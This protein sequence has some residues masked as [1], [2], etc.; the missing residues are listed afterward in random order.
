MKLKVYRIDGTQ[1]EETVELPPA[2]FEI[3]PNQHL[4]HQA[5]KAHLSNRRQGTHKAKERSDVRGG[6]KKPWKQKGRGTARAGT[7]RSPIWIGGGTTH[8]P[9]PRSYRLNMN[10]RAVRLAKKSALSQKA[11]AGEIMVIEDL[12]FEKPVT[13]DFCS[14]LRN[15]KLENKKILVLLAEGNENIYKSGRNIP[16]VR[17]SR[18]NEAATYDLLNNQVLLIQKSALETLCKPLLN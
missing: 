4:M 11:K 17:L 13:K 3:D 18:S 7:N 10:L 1:S 15:L 6:G 5:V 9:R 8:G 12:S 2:I 14:I 16:G